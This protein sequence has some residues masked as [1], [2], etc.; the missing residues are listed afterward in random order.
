VGRVEKYNGFSEIINGKY[1]H[2][3]FPFINSENPLY[4]PSEKWVPSSDRKKQ[5]RTLKFSELVSYI[6]MKI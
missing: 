5:A 4:F 1:F 2:E 3:Y 6:I